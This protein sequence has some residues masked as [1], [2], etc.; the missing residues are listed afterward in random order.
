MDD[1]ERQSLELTVE[2]VY[3][4]FTDCFLKEEEVKDG[5]PICDYTVGEGIIRSFGFNS[6]RLQQHDIDIIDMIDQLP[7]IEEGP[8]FLNLCMTKEG[9]HWGH[10]ANMEQLVALGVASGNLSYCLP[11]AMWAKL[12]GGVPMVIKSQKDKEKELK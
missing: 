12:P 8:S 4:V 6:E 9:V 7:D 1:T 10:H 11:R 5:K 2:N 3:N